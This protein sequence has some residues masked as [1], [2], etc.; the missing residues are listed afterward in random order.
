MAACKSSSKDIGKLNLKPVFNKKI[1]WAYVEL[2]FD[3][4]GVCKKL[5]KYVV[6]SSIKKNQKK[7]IFLH[8]SSLNSDQL[9][10]GLKEF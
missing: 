10:F 4:L 7:F 6:H 2:E 3:M 5:A 8:T 9:V 1:P